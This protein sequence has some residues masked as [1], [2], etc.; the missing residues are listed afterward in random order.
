MIE[1]V[2]SLGVCTGLVVLLLGKHF[3][4]LLREDGTRAVYFEK[5][6]AFQAGVSPEYVSM[7]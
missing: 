7:E 3:C 5:I 4:A 2:C 6:K 1:L